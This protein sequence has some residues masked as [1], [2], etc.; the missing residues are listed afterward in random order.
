MIPFTI[1]GAVI[2]AVIVIALSIALLV[3]VSSKPNTFS[4]KRDIA[5]NGQPDKIF[6]LINNFHRWATWSP[7]DKKDPAMKRT[8]S[9]SESGVGAVYEWDGNKEV[10]IG[11]MEII[12]AT[13]PSKIRIKLDF[14]APFEGHN[15]AEFSIEQVGSESIVTWAMTGPSNFMMKLMHCFMDMDKLVGTDFESGLANMKSVVESSPK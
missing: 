11:K 1:V 2:V 6:P 12:E 4:V 7:Y 15:T 8:Y 3:F 9:G 13:A 14:F 5:I 10:G